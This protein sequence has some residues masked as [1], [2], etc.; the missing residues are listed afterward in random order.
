MAIAI[1]RLLGDVLLMCP[2][3]H[4]WKQFMWGQGLLGWPKPTWW[5]LSRGGICHAANAKAEWS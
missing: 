1:E 2:L 5:T 3:F 4:V